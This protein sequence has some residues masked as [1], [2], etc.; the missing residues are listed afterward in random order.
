MVKLIK[1]SHDYEKA[2][3]R[4]AELMQYTHQESSPESDEL[5]LYSLL[6]KE[7][8]QANRI[9]PALTPIEAIRSRL[10]QLGMKES[11]LNKILGFRSRK[12]E[13]LNGKR[14]LTL[15]MIRALHK[16]LN[17]PAEVLIGEY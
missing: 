4:V 7:Y 13:I 12:S 9:T 1:T 2:L 8:E 17:I 6:I 16:K 14:K 5:K 3:V 11:E 15:S 10:D